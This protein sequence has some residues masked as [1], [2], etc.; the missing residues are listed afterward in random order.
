MLG[1]GIDFRCND[2]IGVSSLKNKIIDIDKFLEV[3]NSNGL[4]NEI[5]V[6][7]TG[8]SGYNSVYKGNSKLNYTNNI[9]DSYNISKF[10]LNR[11]AFLYNDLFNHIDKNDDYMYFRIDL[12]VLTQI[13]ALSQST[14]NRLSEFLTDEF[15]SNIHA[16]TGDELIE[17]YG[18]HVLTEI[19]IGKAI[20]LT[21]ATYR[22]D[23][24]FNKFIS[25]SDKYY[26]LFTS[27][28]PHNDA[29]MVF[30]D[31]EKVDILFRSIDGETFIEPFN[32]V[33]NNISFDYPAW[34]QG[35]NGNSL[36]GVKHFH[37]NVQLLSNFIDDDMKRYE[38]EKAILK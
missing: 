14:S 16:L 27:S 35:D 18:T 13:I 10:I 38:V 3:N 17:K 29:K 9:S 21:F 37:T 36:V 32:G 23:D 34:L 33:I 8:K 24:L 11:Q 28:T 31:F 22:S 6:I 5:F 30:N 1:Y 4:I 26:E 7:K 2:F 12:I 19:K 25:A 20:S 15:I